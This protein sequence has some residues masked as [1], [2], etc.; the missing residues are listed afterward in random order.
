MNPEQ[1]VSPDEIRESL[2]MNTPEVYD[3]FFE[4]EAANANIEIELEADK[5]VESYIPDEDKD[6]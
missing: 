2:Q 6:L 4:M 1:I 3:N 5:I